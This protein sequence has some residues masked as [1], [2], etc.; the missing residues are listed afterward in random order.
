MIDS[1]LDL[2]LCNLYFTTA[3]AADYTLLLYVYHD[4]K[5]V[6]RELPENSLTLEFELQANQDI[7]LQDIITTYIHA[8]PAKVKGLIV[9]SS[10]APAY[11]TLR[12]YKLTY[13]LQNLHS[14]IARPNMNGGSAPDTQVTPMLFDNIDI[15]FQYSH[16]REASGNASTQ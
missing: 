8:L 13:V 10:S 2:S 6:D 3:P 11:I 14:E 5:V 7:N 16:I 1:K 12:D 4:T 15:D 9:W